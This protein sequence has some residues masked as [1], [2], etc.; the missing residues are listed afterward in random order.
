MTHATAGT[1]CASTDSNTLAISVAKISHHQWVSNIT[2]VGLTE[3]FSNQRLEER[4]QPQ[5]P[6]QDDAKMKIY[7]GASILQ[8]TPGKDFSSPVGLPKS[9]PQGSRNPFIT[10]TWRKQV[11]TPIYTEYKSVNS[12]ATM[13]KTLMK[14][15]KLQVVAVKILNSELYYA[16]LY[17]LH[18]VIF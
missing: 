11:P 18:K 4:Y 12:F 14:M 8:A 16:M 3:S 15:A 17:F 1:W 10:N 5:L 6:F 13:A 9:T 7:S 2:A